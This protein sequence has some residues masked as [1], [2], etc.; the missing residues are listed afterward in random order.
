MFIHFSNWIFCWFILYKLKIIKYNPELFLLFG[1]IDNIIGLILMLKYNKILLELIFHFI[2]KL[3]MF[4][5]LKNTKYKKSDFIFGLLLYFIYN[6]W[7]FQVKN[8]TIIKLK[9]Q[10]FD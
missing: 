2:L 1:I 6:L 8:L 5:S 3:I 4:Y 9:Y 7:L 10:K